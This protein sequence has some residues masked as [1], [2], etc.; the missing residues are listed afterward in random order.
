M[1]DFDES[2]V[3]D[4][5]SYSMKVCDRH[6]RDFELGTI[7]TRT[8]NGPNDPGMSQRDSGLEYRSLGFSGRNLSTKRFV[9]FPLEHVYNVIYNF[10]VL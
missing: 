7:W 2:H 1:S 9:N 4:V 6:V 10:M 8:A 3:T 5:L